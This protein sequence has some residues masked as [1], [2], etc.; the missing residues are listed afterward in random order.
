MQVGSSQPLGLLHEPLAHLG[1]G[2]R[3]QFAPQVHHPVISVPEAQPPP[4]P[5]APVLVLA[6]VV[7]VL[8]R[9]TASLCGELLRRQLS[10]LRQQLSISV[11]LLDARLARGPHQRL[12]VGNRDL[13]GLHRVTHRRHRLQALRGPDPPRR[14]LPKEPRGS[15]EQPNARIAM[16]LPGR[17][18]NRG[19]GL[20]HRHLSTE[21]LRP[22]Q[23]L[24]HIRC[25]RGRI[26]H[27]TDQ[28]GE[29]LAHLILHPPCR[30]G[31]HEH[32]MP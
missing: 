25:R 16:T 2:H 7:L 31:N 14:V 8:D 3:V 10:G 13:T 6:A 30:V 29:T 23:H 18:H 20:K 4:G 11:N 32:I 21:S 5:L 12:G 24:A 28:L 15:G 22:G 17:D 27:Q 9:P 19:I 26:V 1:P